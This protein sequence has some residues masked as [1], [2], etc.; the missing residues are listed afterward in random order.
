MGLFC[1]LLIGYLINYDLSPDS[2]YLGEEIKLKY[3]VIAARDIEFSLSED[4]S[5]WHPLILTEPLQSELN[6]HGDDSI[7]LDLIIT[8]KIFTELDSAI[9]SP[10][11]LTITNKDSTYQDSLSSLNITIL[12]TLAPDDDFEPAPLRPRM[13]FP[14]R[15]PEP[16]Y[17]K[18]IKLLV[19]FWYLPIVLILIVAG[20]VLIWVLMRRH[21]KISKVV[22]NPR[23]TALLDLMTVKMKYLNSDQFKF[24]NFYE[25]LTDIFKDYTEQT[26]KYATKKMTSKE[27]RENF[28]T[29]FNINLEVD[30]S[31][32]EFHQ[33]AELIKFS[34]YPI[35]KE[36]GEK[37]WGLIK[38]FIEKYPHPEIKDVYE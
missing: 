17:R 3:S 8:G 7:Q 19:K 16:W 32:E 35:E 24:R 9:I 21:Q 14:P 37:D 11:P 25:K 38:E 22:I 28:L 15:P 10:P 13:D 5:S 23:E 4:S 27:I 6:T 26:S 18:G 30:R 36:I 34:K 31:L 20:A 1:I 2:A 12:S 33:L 29:T